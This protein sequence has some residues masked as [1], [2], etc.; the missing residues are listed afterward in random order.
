MI[1]IR[2]KKYAVIILVF[3]QSLL[4]GQQEFQLSTYF[5][6]PLLF[7][8]AYA[9]SQKT[10]VTNLTVRDQWTNFNGAPKS[11][12][13]TMHS[14]L[15]TESLALGITVSNDKIGAH[16]NKY[17]GLDLCTKI[18]LNKRES[19][20]AFALKPSMD[21][22]ETNY[23]NTK[24]QDKTDNIYVNGINNR[25][26]MPN[27]GAGFYLYTKH[28]YFGVSSPRLIQ[29]K[30]QVS[31]S[32]KSYQSNHFYAFS[33]LVLKINSAVYLRPSVLIKYVS[34]APPSIDGNLSILFFDKIWLG[35]MYRYNSATGA[36]V[37]YSISNSF[38]VGYA[39]DYTLNAIQNYSN[40]SHEIMLSY[41]LHNKNK[42]YTS[43]R[44][45]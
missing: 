43:P 9:G 44:Y 30:F 34:N 21:I 5:F 17:L 36:N 22:Y 14:P 7:N 11:Q 37:M 42:G 24:I 16:T 38:N 45:F 32:K 39:F 13:F 10:L 20:L 29:N 23:S 25:Q 27:I 4:S 8:P 33:G 12:L 19:F 41:K 3:A 35:A 26:V 18:R 31:S 28:Y 2:V 1:V 15:K 40:G 6:S